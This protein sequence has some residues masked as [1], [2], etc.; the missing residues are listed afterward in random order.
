MVTASLFSLSSFGSF[1]P[2]SFSLSFFWLVGDS[3]DAAAV[4]FEA[5]PFVAVVVVAV[6]AALAGVDEGAT[7]AADVSASW[8]ST[9]A[10]R[11]VVTSLLRASDLR[12]GIACVSLCRG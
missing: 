1:G 3:D 6:S 9:R 10:N 12:D 7:A 2:L 8:S 11:A 4:P 5:D